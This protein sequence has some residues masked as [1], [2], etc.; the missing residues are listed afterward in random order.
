LLTEGRHSIIRGARGAKT[1]APDHAC[2]N[3]KQTPSQ[4]CPQLSYGRNRFC[5]VESSLDKRQVALI[6]QQIYARILKS[7]FHSAKYSIFN[8]QY[9]CK[10]PNNTRRCFFIYLISPFLYA[11]LNSL[12]IYF[13]QR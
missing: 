10:C 4:K 5:A 3:V 1:E 6:S 9:A 2:P 11:E 12:L 13:R 7:Q 8:Q